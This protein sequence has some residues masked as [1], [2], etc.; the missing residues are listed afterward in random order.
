MTSGASQARIA[1]EHGGFETAELRA[2]LQA[3]LLD[4]HVAGPLVRADRVGLA[5]GTVQ[6]QHQ[7]GPEPLAQRVASHQRLQ[8]AHEHAVMSEHQVGVDPIL[9]GRE[10][11]LVEPQRLRARPTRPP[12]QSASASPRQSPRP[13]PAPRLARRGVTVDECAVPC[14]RMALEPRHVDR[15]GRTRRT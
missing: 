9:D 2:R 3:Q 1:G 15:I 13:R 5:A 14:R 4:E 8:L 11:Q 6:R 12:R 10:P 7:R